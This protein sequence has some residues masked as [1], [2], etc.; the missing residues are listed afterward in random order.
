MAAELSQSPFERGSG[1][2]LTYTELTRIAASQS[3]F[4]RGS[5]LTGGPTQAP[6]LRRLNPLLNG[7]QV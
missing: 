3:P 5:G 4:E 2:T 1:L 6:E 7:A